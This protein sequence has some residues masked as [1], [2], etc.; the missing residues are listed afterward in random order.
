MKNQ[1][2]INERTEKKSDHKIQAGKSSDRQVKTKGSKS[3]K[4]S[5]EGNADFENPTDD[6]A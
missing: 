5:S 6:P 4:G 3:E 1:K 2:K